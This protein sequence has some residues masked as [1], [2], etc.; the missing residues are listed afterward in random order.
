MSRRKHDEAFPAGSNRDG[1]QAN[2]DRKWIR[3]SFNWRSLVQELYTRECSVCVSDLSLDDF[4]PKIHSGGAQHTCEVCESCWEEH[5]R[6]AV[7]ELE[8]DQIRCAQCDLMLSEPD[9]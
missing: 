4:P 6:I 8:T 3:P 5:L 2:G 9:V 7:E 1:A